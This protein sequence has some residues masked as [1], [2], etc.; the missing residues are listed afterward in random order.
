MELEENTLIVFTSDNGPWLQYGIDAGSAGPF[1]DGKGT[2][3]EGGMRVPGIFCWPGKISADRR[4][5]AVAGNLDLLTTIAHLAG[6]ELPDDRVID[7]KD[8]WPLL[9]GQADTSPHDYFHYYGG[10][11]P[12]G[13]SAYRAIRDARWKLT[14]K[15][16]RDGT[17]AGAELYDLWA[18][19]AE[20]FDRAAQHTETAERLLAAAREFDSNMNDNRRPVGRV[21]R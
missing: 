20:K 17:L 7:G 19:P 11:R 13:P 21:E 5:Q 16:E 6:V 9:S 15:R 12:G 8:L 1:R 14:L 4:T 18:D 10:S 3:W 2:T